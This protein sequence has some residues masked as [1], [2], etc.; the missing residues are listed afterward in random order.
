MIV[1]PGEILDQ[2]ESAQAEIELHIGSEDWKAVDLAN[3]ALEQQLQQLFAL[4]EQHQDK[5]DRDSF[6]A[7]IGRLE[8]ILQRHEELAARVTESR[9]IVSGE[10]GAARRGQ[11]AAG[12]YLDTAGYVQ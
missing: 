1:R 4:L 12:K 5:V 9:N 2:L 7:V 11:K 10:L 6:L 8:S 3:A